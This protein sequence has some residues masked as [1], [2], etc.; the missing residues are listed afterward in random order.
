MAGPLLRGSPGMVSYAF[1]IFCALCPDLTV[2][3][4]NFKFEILNFKFE[5]LN[6][7]SADRCTKS[8][9]PVLSSSL[10]PSC[11]DTTKTPRPA[12]GYPTDRGARVHRKTSR[13]KNGDP[14]ATTPRVT[15]RRQELLRLVRTGNVIWDHS[16][17]L[18]KVSRTAGLDVPGEVLES[19]ISWSMQSA[20]SRKGRL[21]IVGIAGVLLFSVLLVYSLSGE[22]PL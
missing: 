7:K 15:Q 1:R 14:P 10:G 12:E 3:I 16:R 9:G 18:A 5:I 8:L 4:S 21:N 17:S 13:S 22:A 11:L 20:G 2:E 6:F 19:D